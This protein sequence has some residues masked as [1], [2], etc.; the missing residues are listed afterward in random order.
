M[1]N[2]P[3]AAQREEVLN[4]AKS[5][6][7]YCQSQENYSNST[8]EVEHIL[9]IS[10]AGKTVLE[11]LAFACSGCNKFKSDRIAGFD[12]QSQ[13]EVEFYNPRKDRWHEHFAWNE[14]FTEIISKTPKGRV[15]I[16]ALKLNRK[17]LI[18]LRRVLILAGEH[19]PNIE[20]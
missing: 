13:T 8:F 7:E 5:L 12:A 14:D 15:T 1:S 17:N 4:R 2:R 19:P 9:P 20:K 11:N 18:N 6:C 10:K 16:K 3:T